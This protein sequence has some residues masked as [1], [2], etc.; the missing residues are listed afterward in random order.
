MSRFGF[1]LELSGI[2]ARVAGG[3]LIARIRAALE[4]APIEAIVGRLL[5]VARLR[6]AHLNAAAARARRRF[7]RSIAF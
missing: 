7:V 3:K 6:R 2:L 4:A 1:Y 5:R